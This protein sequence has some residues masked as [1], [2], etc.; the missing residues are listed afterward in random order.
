MTIGG[1]SIILILGIVNFAHGEFFMAGAYAVWFFYSKLGWPFFVAVVAA[2]VI[3]T[4]I[5]LLMERGLF[6][7]MR[8]NPLGG[9]INSIGVFV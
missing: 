8:G 7:P 5:G 9:L 6:R 4:L 1:V 2:I 3:V